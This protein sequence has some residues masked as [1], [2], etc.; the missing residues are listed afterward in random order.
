MYIKTQRDVRYNLNG[1]DCSLS[2][3]ITLPVMDWSFYYMQY[4][5]VAGTAF[6][7]S[8]ITQLVAANIQH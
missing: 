7:F 2:S 8:S 1:L 6:V 5:Y 4:L 3:S